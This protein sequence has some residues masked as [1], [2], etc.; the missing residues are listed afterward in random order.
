MGVNSKM[1]LGDGDTAQAISVRKTY[2]RVVNSA[3]SMPTAAI[4]ALILSDN[5]HFH[6]HN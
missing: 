4:F 3:G 1:G 2:S 6:R 5:L